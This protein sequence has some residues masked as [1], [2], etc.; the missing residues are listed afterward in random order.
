MKRPLT[1]AAVLGL[2][3]LVIAAPARAAGPP[4]PLPVREYQLPAITETRLENGLQVVV[5]QRPGLPVVRADVVLPGGDSAE[6]ASL[7][8]LADAAADLVSVE[9]LNRSEEAIEA[10]TDGLGARLQASSGRDLLTVSIST[11][12]EYAEPGFDLLADVVR[13][14]AFPADELEELRQQLLVDLQARTADPSEVAGRV[15]NALLYG[16]HPYGRALTAQSAQAMTRD[17]LVRFW[18][19]QATPDRAFLVIVGDLAPDHAVELART[20]F[21]DWRGPARPA[22]RYAAPPVRTGQ[23]IYLVDRPGSTQAEMRLGQLVGRAMPREDRIGLR[24]LNQVLGADGNARLFQNLR[25]Q[26]GYTYGAYSGFAFSLDQASFLAQAAVRNEVA[27]EALRE[28]LREVQRL[29]QEPVPSDELGAAKDYLVGSFA[30]ALETNGQIANEL[31]GLKA[32]G[33][34]YSDLST[35]IGLVESFGPGAVQSLAGRYLRPAE[36]AVVVVGDASLIRAQL[37]AVAPVI[38]VDTDG[39]PVP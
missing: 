25:E 39:R 18:Q 30:L 13:N 36:A 23:T 35:Y 31:I 15:L 20:A 17:D 32:R 11:L 28:L 14:P 3:A 7:P 26:K 9:T 2:S 8:G 29:R 34:P 1:T 4:E 37:E 19:Q 6:P 33:R 21:G 16:P 38:L 12:S 5:V 24:V 22:T 27:G 10:A